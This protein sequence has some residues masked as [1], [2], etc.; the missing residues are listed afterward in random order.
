MI[1]VARC[2]AIS[3]QLYWQPMRTQ[4]GISRGTASYSTLT[5][6][7]LL[8]LAI[9]VLLLLLLG[10]LLFQSASAQR[11]Q[12]ERRVLQ[13]LDALVNSVDRDLDR[14]LTILRTLATSQALGSEDWRAF[15]DQATA[16]LQGRAYLILIDA[17][18]RQLVNTYV[19]YGQQPAMTGD[20]ETLR[21][22]L[23]TGTPVVS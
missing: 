16:G 20:P 21:R 4:A 11:E 8:G 3:A 14:D 18:G 1:A 13:V 23:Q 7:W 17:T 15:Y 9:T 5:Y 12:L 2:F 22:M 19:P 6:L 10:A